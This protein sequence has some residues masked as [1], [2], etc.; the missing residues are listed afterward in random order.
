[1]S[2]VPRDETW[3]LA[4]DGRWYPPVPQ[5]RSAPAP[6]APRTNTSAIVSLVLGVLAITSCGFF[7]G[8][9]A[10]LVARKARREIAESGGVEG[11]QGLARA[12]QITGWIGSLFY[13]LM[14]V[15]I[16][17]I[18]LFVALVADFPEEASEQ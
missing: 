18:A 13:L 15:A 5:R 1:M 6:P 8:I 4:S 9:P 11:G 7:L 10:I 16:G 12:G 17:G 2:D 14:V 3:W